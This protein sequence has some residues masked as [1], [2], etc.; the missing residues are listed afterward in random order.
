MGLLVYTTPQGMGNFIVRSGCS[1]PHP[2]EVSKSLRMEISQPSPGTCSSSEPLSSMGYSFPIPVFPSSPKNHEMSDKSACNLL[3]KQLYRASSMTLPVQ[4]TQFGQWQ[5]SSYFLFWVSPWWSRA[6]WDIPHKQT[7]N[8]VILLPSLL[9]ES[10][11]SQQV[12]MYSKLSLIPASFTQ[13]NS[14]KIVFVKRE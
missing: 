11:N 14:F 10:L 4:T 3:I 5:A 9:L 8:Q 7:K 1:R 12:A 6:T 13:S 2:K